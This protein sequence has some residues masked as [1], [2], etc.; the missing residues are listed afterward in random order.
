MQYHLNG[1]RAG[2]PELHPA[3]REQGD[4]PEEVDVLIVG[5]GPAGLTLAAY[6]AGFPGITT[7]IVE[8]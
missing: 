8:R 2:D 7:R 5:C 4:L 1:Y 3:A 6:L